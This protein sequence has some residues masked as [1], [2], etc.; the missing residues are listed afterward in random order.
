[1]NTF[2][3]IYA[4]DLNDAARMLEEHAGRA[5]L[6][7]G[8]SDLLAMMKDRVA[9]PEV[10]INLQRIP[11]IDSIES[12]GGRVSIGGLTKLRALEH[13]AILGE[14]MT[15]LTR[16]AASVASPPIRNVATVGGN[17]AQRTRCWYY[18]GPFNCWLKGGTECYAVEG[19]NKNHAIFGD[20]PC[21]MIQASDLATAL[22]ALD[23]EVT[24]VG[25]RN[26]RSI[27][28][29]DFFVNPSSAWRC[30]VALQHDEIVAG[31]S[32]SYPPPNA[33][34]GF[35][36]AMERAAW[37][38]AII[39]IGYSVVAERGFCSHV[40]IALGG[41]ATTPIRALSAERELEGN[42]LSPKLLER[43]AEALVE[44]ARPLSQ[45]AYKLPLLKG[46]FL[47]IFQNIMQTG[48]H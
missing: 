21:Y 15:V 10:L 24:V 16:A 46:Y 4:I 28:A 23:G 14:R 47:G 42:V 11:G 2:V 3:H 17:L 8:G 30:E 7:S 27:S 31:I 41:V 9:T 40:R 45:N 25:P 19:E 12:D 20:G 38:A 44:T 6:V 22:V 39:S 34:T 29:K 36:K 5:A 33:S 18:R 32:A 35:V 26:L 48:P 37:D 43:A 1:V 13:N